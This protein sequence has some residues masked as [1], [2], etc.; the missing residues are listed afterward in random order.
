MFVIEFYVICS[1]VAVNIYFSLRISFYMLFSTKLFGFFLLSLKK[2]KKNL[3]SAPVGLL[4][5][6]VSLES[7]LYMCCLSFST[8]EPLL[9]HI[10][11]TVWKK[12]E[13]QIVQYFFLFT[14]S[15]KTCLYIQQ[16]PL[17]IADLQL[18]YPIL[19]ISYK[20]TS[21]HE[22]KKDR[23]CC[24]LL[25]VFSLFFLFYFVI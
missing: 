24:C 25:P 9:S 17:S 10:A 5:F 7:F 18:T 21:L 23:P 2:K 14:V 22:K 4:V 1:K 3:Y 8:T 16:L 19:I 6:T 15:F 13:I 12:T 11:V 20:K